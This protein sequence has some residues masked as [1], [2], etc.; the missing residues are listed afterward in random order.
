MVGVRLDPQ[1][2]DLQTWALMKV[3]QPGDHVIIVQGLRKNEIVD[4]NGKSSLLSL[5]KAFDS[6]LAVYDDFRNLKQAGQKLK[7][8]R[9]TFSLLRFR[10]EPPL[11]LLLCRVDLWSS[12]TRNKQESW[13]ENSIV[14]ARC[15]KKCQRLEFIAKGVIE[16]RKRANSIHI[17][18]HQDRS[19]TKATLF[20]AAQ[21]VIAIGDP[22]IRWTQGHFQTDSAG[23]KASR[24][25]TNPSYIRLYRYNR[26]GCVEFQANAV[27]ILGQ[28]T[29]IEFLNKCPIKKQTKK[30]DT[31]NI[32]SETFSK[33]GD[34]NDGLPPP[35][36]N[37]SQKYSSLLV[38]ALHESSPLAVKLE[39]LQCIYKFCEG[40]ID[41]RDEFGY[42][43]VVGNLI[44][45]VLD[46]ASHREPKLRFPVASILKQLLWANLIHPTHLYAIGDPD[47]ERKHSLMEGASSFLEP[48]V[49]SY[50]PEFEGLLFGLATRNRQKGRDRPYGFY[51]NAS[52]DQLTNKSISTS[53]VSNLRRFSSLS[54]SRLALHQPIIDLSAMD[55][56][57]LARRELQNLC[58]KMLE[59][60]EVETPST[61]KRAP[62][63]GSTEKG[64]HY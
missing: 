30:N 14:H 60:G 22:K 7:V 34:M 1:S 12:S 23:S 52:A 28:L 31:V 9:G 32:A 8:S 55:F 59:R 10:Q 5:V 37:H 40:I 3:A 56:Y 24:L 27:K 48:T 19:K 50:V 17:R 41:L 64:R 6:V 49:R 36:F 2:R 13:M 29:T 58:K 47:N 11:C 53:P 38:K 45:I 54:L 25:A 26:L 20:V 18:C 61:Q 51:K 42:A 44:C 35:N 57:N 46:A 4:R 39:A 43:A 16:A 33:D 21:G 63:F 15:S 62:N